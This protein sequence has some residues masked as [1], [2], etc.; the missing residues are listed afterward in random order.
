MA[1]NAS[2]IYSRVGSIGYPTTAANSTLTA[3]TSP[4]LGGSTGTLGIITSS[5]YFGTSTNTAVCFT[6]DATNGGFV[7]RIRFK[8]ANTNTTAAVG[9]IWIN[10]GNA[11][12]QTNN[13]FFGEISLPIVTTSATAATVDIDYPMNFALPPNYRI[14]IGISSSAILTG[15]GWIPTVIAGAY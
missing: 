4:N 2:P 14:V 15:G 5:D 9:R 8:A 10:N 11:F 6:A 13:Y 12:G 1:G 7:Q 3:I